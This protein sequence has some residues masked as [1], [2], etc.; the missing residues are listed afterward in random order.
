MSTK[1]GKEPI[2]NKRYAGL[3]EVTPNDQNRLALSK[4]QKAYLVSNGLECRFIQKKEY[5]ANNNFH[6]TGWTI[7]SDSEMPGT[8]AE[9]L[10]EVGD[11][12]LA[13]KTKSA[14][15]AHRKN[16]AAKNARYS[17]PKLINKKAAAEL[18]S[19][20]SEGNLS[21]QIHEGYS[22]NGDEADDDQYQLKYKLF[23]AM[24]LQNHL[25][26]KRFYWMKPPQS[27]G[28]DI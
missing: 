17:D 24:L 22:E 12:V 4:E 16:L 13:V 2:A 8:N 19:R 1:G 3:L 5:L 27:H 9:G 11:L 14:Q 26:I 10:V 21:G 25:V 20:M 28:G 23:L 7:V 18:R 15:N 6:R